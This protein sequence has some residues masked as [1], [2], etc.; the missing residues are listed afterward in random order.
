MKEPHCARYDANRGLC[1]YIGGR[2]V[3]CSNDPDEIQSVFSGIGK[4]FVNLGGAQFRGVGL[5]YLALEAAKA[6][7]CS[8]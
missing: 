2:E 3:Y 4:G 6:W 7:V 5:K 1:A 8:S